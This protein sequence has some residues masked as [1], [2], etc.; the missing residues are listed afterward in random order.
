MMFLPELEGDESNKM[1]GEYAVDAVMFGNDPLAEHP[2][3]VIFA[4]FVNLDLVIRQK[5]ITCI[6]K[7]VV[8]IQTVAVVVDIVAQNVQAPSDRNRNIRA[9]REELEQKLQEL[10]ASVFVLFGNITILTLY[11]KIVVNQVGSFQN[12]MV[13]QRY[14]N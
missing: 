7:T 2:G 6:D 14:R 4:L 3:V 8:C 11:G 9:L 13:V 12:K 1:T 10:P 5:I